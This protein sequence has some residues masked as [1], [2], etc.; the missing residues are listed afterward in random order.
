MPQVRNE[1]MQAFQPEADTVFVRRLASE[2]RARQAET[3]VRLPTSTM[4]VRELPEATLREMVRDGIE[5]ARGYGMT[6]EAGLACF[7]VLMFVVSPNFD[8]HPAIKLRLTDEKVQA[9][10]R[11]KGLPKTVAEPD[12]EAARSSYEPSA[13]KVAQ[14]G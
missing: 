2:I 1:Q 10:A 11:V 7:V 9:D 6:S 13:W 14:G 4:P 5:R 3:V 12:W 8:E